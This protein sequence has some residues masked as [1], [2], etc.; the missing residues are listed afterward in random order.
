MND[1][2]VIHIKPREKRGADVGARLRQIEERL[3]KLEE[4]R[5]HRRQLARAAHHVSKAYQRLTG[6]MPG[7]QRTNRTK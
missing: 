1:D 5:D 7:K 3:R 6:T 2:R 4:E